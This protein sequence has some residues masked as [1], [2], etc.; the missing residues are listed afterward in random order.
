MEKEK[1]G[2]DRWTFWSNLHIQY[3][4]CDDDYMG[5]YIGKTTQLP[6]ILTFPNVSINY[7]NTSKC[8]PNP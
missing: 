1:K 7:K 4:D 5:V 8:P 6:D 2:D 3:F